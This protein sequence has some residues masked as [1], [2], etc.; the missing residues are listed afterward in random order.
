M[1]LNQQMEE[2]IESDQNI[3]NAREKT[4]DQY[5]IAGNPESAYL[6]IDGYTEHRTL[7]P[8]VGF[9]HSSKGGLKQM[10]SRLMGVK[11]VCGQNV[12]T[13]FNY[14]TSSLVDGGANLMIQVIS[15]AIE[16]LSKLLATYG[17]VLPRKLFFQLDNCGENKN[18][19]VFSYLSLLVEKSFFDI[20][21][22]NFLIVGHTHGYIDQYFSTRSRLRD[23]TTFI[24]S[25]LS[26]WNTFNDDQCSISKEITIIYNWK[27]WFHPVINN[28]LKFYQLPHVFKFRRHATDNFRKLIL[29]L[30]LI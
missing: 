8:K 21:Q 22:V 16:D 27:S 6:M 25:P 20:I 30:T 10:T 18:K 11:V 4:T 26:L 3:V 28:K 24:G 17:Q 14:Y 13:H 7:T 29:Q 19:Y 23:Q 5:G 2:R 1:H 12:D 9:R 15:N